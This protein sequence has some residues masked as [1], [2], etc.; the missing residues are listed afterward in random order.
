MLSDN[1]DGILWIL[2]S[3]IVLTLSGVFLSILVDKRFSFQRETTSIQSLLDA[4]E[5][6]ILS[7]RSQIRESEAILASSISTREANKLKLDSS[8]KNSKIITAEINRLEGRKSELA[9]RIPEAKEAFYKYRENYREQTWRNAIGEKIEYIMLKSGRQFDKVVIQKVIPSG[10][11]ISHA[12]GL[13]RINGRDLS[14]AM[15]ARFQWIDKEADHAAQKQEIAK[16]SE[17][18][19]ILETPNKQLENQA[20]IRI[21]EENQK[22]QS[23]AETRKLLIKGRTA[24]SSLRIMHSEA[25]SN[26]RYGSERSVPGSL[27]TWAEQA[28][29]LEKKLTAATAKLSLITEQLR[30]LSPADPLLQFE[31]R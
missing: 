27:R 18:P 3:L 15:Q 10:L 2:G 28:E 9:L 14:H 8:I 31:Y 23:I 5:V 25:V 11:V 22:K 30:Q 12:H 29:I 4:N 19:A 26:S 7:L 24:V 6:S 1:Q 13:A 17:Q 16:A 20:K 21:E